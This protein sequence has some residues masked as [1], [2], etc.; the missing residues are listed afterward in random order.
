VVLRPKT[1]PASSL[2]S[3]P[4]TAAWIFEQAGYS[5]QLDPL[6]ILLQRE[7][8]GEFTVHS[9]GGVN[10]PHFDPSFN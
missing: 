5:G 10:Y 7:A 9:E 2:H 6:A 4:D 8:E 1:V 3:D